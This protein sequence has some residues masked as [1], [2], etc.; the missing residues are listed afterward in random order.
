MLI[1]PGIPGSITAKA[2]GDMSIWSGLTQVPHASTIIIVTD[3]PF[4]VSCTAT[5][6]PQANPP[7]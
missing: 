1:W 5:Q 6:A 3:F 7:W 4:P 2:D